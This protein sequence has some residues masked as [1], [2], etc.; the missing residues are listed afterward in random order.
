ME[1]STDAMIETN[2]QIRV[3]FCNIQW[4]GIISNRLQLFNVWLTGCTTVIKG[5]IG[6]LFK[7]FSF[8]GILTKMISDWLAQM[9]P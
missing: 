5:P 9:R 3:A 8:S 2:F 1:E 4:V 7:Y 6:L